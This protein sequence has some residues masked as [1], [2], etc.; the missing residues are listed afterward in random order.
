M[1]GFIV[2]LIILLSIET[3]MSRSSF[4]LCAWTCDS[5]ISLV[6]YIFPSLLFVYLELITKEGF[7]HNFSI[8][9]YFMFL[10]NVSEE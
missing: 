5:L 8:P 10:R 4:Y 7:W 2:I 6:A 3:R 9:F 1:N